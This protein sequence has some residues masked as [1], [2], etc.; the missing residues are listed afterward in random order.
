MKSSAYLNLFGG[1][2]QSAIADAVLDSVIDGVTPANKAN[3]AGHFTGYEQ[4]AER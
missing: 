2:V 3:D 1:P 4:F